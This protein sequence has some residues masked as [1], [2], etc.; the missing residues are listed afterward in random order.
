[1]LPKRHLGDIYKH[2]FSLMIFLDLSLNKSKP[3]LKESA[4][5]LNL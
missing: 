3:V 2:L 1:M 5:A 4:L